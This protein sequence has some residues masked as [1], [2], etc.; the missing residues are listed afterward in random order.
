MR[1]KE[2]LNLAEE[3]V[4]QNWMEHPGQMPGPQAEYERWREKMEEY[5]SWRNEIIAQVIAQ[6]VP[7]NRAKN[8][9]MKAIRRERGRRR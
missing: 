7:Q 4:H 9:V 8:L 3:L 2:M 5:E 1:Y 6:G